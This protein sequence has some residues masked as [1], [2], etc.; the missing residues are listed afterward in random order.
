MS[1]RPS[2]SHASPNADHRRNTKSPAD[3]SPVKKRVI[4]LGGGFGGLAFCHAIDTIRA[5][6]ILI[7]RQNHHLFQPLLY[8]VATAGLSVPDIAHPIRSIF[9]RKK[10]VDVRLD[11]ALQVDVE[12]KNIRLRDTGTLSYDYLVIGVGARTNYFGNDQWEAFAPGLKTLDDAALLRQRILFSFERAELTDDPEER[13]RLMTVVVVGGGPTGVEL[14]GAFTELSRFVLRRDFRRIDPAQT[15]IVLLEATDRILRQFSPGLAAKARKQLE[16]LGVEIQLNAKIRSIDETGVTLEDGSIPAAN[17]VWGAGVRASRLCAPLPV[18]HDRAGRV[19]VAPD[20][21]LPDHPEVFAIGDIVNL[22]DANGK[23]VP[24]VSP[25]AMQMG[26]HAA[27][28]INRELRGKLNGRKPFRYVD[29]GS[30]ATI[31]RSKAVADIRGLEFAGFPAWMAWLVVHLIFLVGFRNRVSV[32]ISWMYN[33][34]TYRGGARI[35]TGLDRMFRLTNPKARP[36][37][38]VETK[39]GPLP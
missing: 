29:K 9:R 21:S 34:F 26:R 23:P 22:V 14:A 4:M 1:S 18:E 19:K 20:L 3:T 31:G 36:R 15:R 35:I 2:Q 39:P 12:N 17:V 11:E 33:Y 7:D 38:V 16:K 6:V 24:G 25:A 37:S 28:I 13:A 27:A 32:M 5:E 10:G 8:Q 30:M